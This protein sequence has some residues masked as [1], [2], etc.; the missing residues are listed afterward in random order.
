MYLHDENSAHRTLAVDLSARGFQVWQ[1]Y[2]D[3]M[4]ILRSLFELA[5]TTRKEG[6][7]VSIRS[8]TKQAKA[9]ILQIATSNT[10]QFMT[11]LL[12]DIIHPST[13]EHS[14]SIL[15]LLALLIRKVIKAV[16][17]I[18]QLIRSH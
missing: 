15:Q 17:N 9:A 6:D 1:H 10:A 8:S 14:R 5:T 16:S 4:E 7:V 2:V 11:K 3:T 18:L 12:L 13:P